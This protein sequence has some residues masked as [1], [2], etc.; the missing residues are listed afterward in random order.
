MRQCHLQLMSDCALFPSFD[1]PNSESGHRGQRGVTRESRE[2]D[3]TLPNNGL[4]HPHQSRSSDLRRGGLVWK[5]YRRIVF[6]FYASTNRTAY[7]NR[8]M[9]LAASGNKQ[10]AI[11]DYQKA[12]ELSRAQGNQ[13][14]LE[15]ATNNLK[16]LQQ[17]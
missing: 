4:F 14:L 9:A 5:R 13:Q 2:R 6:A 7:R 11:A 16:R 1:L 3:L 8:G 12:L 17:L 10:G 15:S